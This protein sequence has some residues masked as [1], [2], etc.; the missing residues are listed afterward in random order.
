MGGCQGA[1]P[2]VE[3]DASTMPSAVRVERV[4]AD[5][6]G[7][8]IAAPGV[9]AFD[10][11][12]VAA[13]IPPVQGRVVRL[14]AAT[15][16]HV[17]VGA[18]LALVYSADVAG[19]GAGLAEARIARIA[20]EQSLARAERL[21]AEG[22][23]SQREVVDART[24]L[25][26]A[27]AEETRA[28]GV[29]RSLGAQATGAGTYTL[30]SPIA[31]TVVRRGLRVG[32]EARPDASEPAF[33]VADL[34]HLWVLAYLHEGQGS[35]VRP[36][37]VAEVTLPSLPGAPYRATVARVADAAEP[38]TRALVA[39]IP[40]ANPDG[41]LR[42]EMFARVT[43]RA[44]TRQAITVPVTAVISASGE[45]TVVVEPSPGR[46]ERRAVVVGAELGDRVQVLRGLVP[47]ERVVTRGAL[48]VAPEAAQVL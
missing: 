7:A 31:G 39:R 41:A 3:A 14:L 30:R 18:P 9:V 35:V 5:R 38:D 10:E 25:A 32:A 15:G 13:I 16:D 19:A 1:T 11:E 28:A 45:P 24:I 44:S 36:G 6:E 33:L 43:I 2:A 46:Y 29:L 21:A 17:S 42:P 23:G 20:A 37:D 48:L 26:T 47:G 27:R 22:A 34:A 40:V 8:A 4:E 12:R